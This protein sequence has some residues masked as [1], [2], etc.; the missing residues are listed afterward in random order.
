M[1][2]NSDSR[3]TSCRIRT[4]DEQDIPAMVDLWCE[5]MDYHHRLDPYFTLRPDGRRRWGRFVL[6]NL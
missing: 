4:A 1:Q 2:P 6:E 3:E 5:F